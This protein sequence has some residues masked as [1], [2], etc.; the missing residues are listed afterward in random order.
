M[1][2]HQKYPYFIL[3]IGFILGLIIY[4]ITILNILV[5]FLSSLMVGLIMLIE[6]NRQ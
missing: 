3:P 4:G 1:T 6:N 5:M 2:Q